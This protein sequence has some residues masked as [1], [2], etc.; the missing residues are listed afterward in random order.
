[1]DYF[2]NKK[3]DK[4]IES[5][6]EDKIDLNEF[7]KLLL[8]ERFFNNYPR[9]KSMIKMNKKNRY[10]YNSKLQILMDFATVANFHSFEEIERYLGINE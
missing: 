5:Y 3:I 4:F 1:M 10:P 9:T 2:L 6:R 7:F 8:K